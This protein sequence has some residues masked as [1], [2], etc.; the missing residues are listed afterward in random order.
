ML[1]DKFWKEKNQCEDFNSWL[2]LL[3][4]TVA[5]GLTKVLIMQ[6]NK[7]KAGI[8]ALQGV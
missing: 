8:S 7:I 4:S 5:T 1:L 3:F 6:Y 2:H